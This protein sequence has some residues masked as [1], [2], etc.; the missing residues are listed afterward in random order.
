MAARPKRPGRRKRADRDP[1]PV[2]EFGCW[3]ADLRRMGEWLRD[4]GVETVVMQSTG[5]YWIAVYEVLEQAGFRVWLSNARDTKNLPGR[6]SDVQ[7]CQWLRKLHSYGLLRNS[8]HPNE[9]IRGLRSLWRLR[10]RHVQD[11]S[12]EVQHMQKALTSMNVQLAN[13]IS[14][15]SGVTGMAIIEAILKGERDPWKLAALRDPRVKASVEEIA[16]SLEGTWQEDL[17]FELQ[18][19]VD[20]Y[21]F[22]QKQMAEC[23]QRLALHL[24]AMPD[25]KPTLGKPTAPGWLP[26]KQRRSP[27][28]ESRAAMNR[29]LS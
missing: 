11:A 12:R 17:L 26:L 5:V 18:Q 13:A 10:Q 23:D 8:F 14:D 25:G 22:C 28:S 16:R 3:T 21:R 20:R 24:A 2:Q 6:K 4:C 19:A 9:Q 27:A 7:E 29:S 1:Q 15:V